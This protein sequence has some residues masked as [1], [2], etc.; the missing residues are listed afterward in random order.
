METFTSLRPFVDHSGFK[1]QREARLKK[2]DLAAIDKPIR[3][4]IGRIA[5]LDFC[6]TLQS[7]YGHFVHNLQQN[8]RNTESLPL[9]NTAAEIQYRIAYL[10]FC[11]ENSRSG[12]A[13]FYRLQ[14]LSYIDPGY[15]QFGC[16]DWFWQ[17][18]VNSFVLQ[19]EPD[20]FKYEDEIRI[21]Y[22]EAL[23]LESVRNQFFQNLDILLTKQ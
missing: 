8:I 4:I 3:D 10:A 23:C 13:F 7:C 11:I 18:Q 6:F 16:A 12:K 19:V 21:E 1:H 14:Q 15:V 5:K 22:R 9:L 2:L 20:R 17:Q